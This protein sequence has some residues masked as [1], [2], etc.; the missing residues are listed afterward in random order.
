MEKKAGFYIGRFNPIHNG[1]SAVIS[2]MT[3]KYGGL[4]HVLVGSANA[5]QSLR[6]FFTYSQR[7]HYISKLHR[8]KVAPL[9]DFPSNHEWFKAILDIVAFTG[10]T[11]D[12]VEFFTGCIEDVEVLKQFTNNIVVVNRFDGTTPVISATQ[13][14]D[15]LMHERSVEEFLDPR[16]ASQ[17][18][19][20]FKRNLDEFKKK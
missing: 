11:K 1:H 10:F 17:V 12:Q 3:E 16:I 20:D 2:K 19:I 14:R 9:P 5:P 15:A 18:E 4:S 8:V 7:T 13:V 6:N